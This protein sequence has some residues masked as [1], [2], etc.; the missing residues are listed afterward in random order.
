[1]TSLS[2][3]EDVVRMSLGC[4]WDVVKNNKI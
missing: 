1:M 2:S 4:R 3:T